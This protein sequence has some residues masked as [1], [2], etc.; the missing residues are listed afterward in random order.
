MLKKTGKPE[1]EIIN[2]GIKNIKKNLLPPNSTSGDS[3]SAQY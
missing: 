1:Q 3:G 2:K